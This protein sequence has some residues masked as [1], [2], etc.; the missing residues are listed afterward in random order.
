[1]YTSNSYIASVYTLGAL[2]SFVLVFLRPP[3]LNPSIELRRAPLSPLE[4]AC[5]W[6][7]GE[8]VACTGGAGG[9]RGGAGGAGVEC[10]GVEV[11]G[12]AWVLG[13]TSLLLD[14]SLSAFHCCLIRFV[15]SSCDC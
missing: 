2:L 14:F 1:M 7:A 15:F 5:L 8:G 6:G 3:F 11:A 4:A 10:V 13:L 12:A 9:A